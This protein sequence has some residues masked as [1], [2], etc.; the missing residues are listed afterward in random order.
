MNKYHKIVIGGILLAVMSV[1]LVLDRFKSE[2]SISEYAIY[3]MNDNWQVA[4][5]SA[6]SLPY[7]GQSEPGTGCL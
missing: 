6:A 4:G 3:D 2:D 5:D 7:A 1:F